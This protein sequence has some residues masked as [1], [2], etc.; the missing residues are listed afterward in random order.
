MAWTRRPDQ[1]VTRDRRGWP[2]GK[3]RR[4]SSRTAEHVLVLH[5]A[6]VRKPNAYFTGATAIEQAWRTTYPDAPSPSL[7]FIGRTLR[8]HGRTRPDYPKR[9]G[10]ARYLAYPAQTLAGLG[11]TTLEIDFIGRKYIDGHT[12]PLC[13]IAFSLRGPRILKY[14]KRIEAESAEQAIPACREFFRRFERP[15]VAKVDNGFGF[16]AS[17]RWA[18]TVGPMT[19]FLLQERVIPVFTAPRR[20]WNQASVEGA[21]SVFGRK[22]WRRFRFRT[23]TEVD[24][25]LVGFN[26]AYRAYTGYHAPPKR[27][28]RS[29]FTPIVYYIRKVQE[30]AGRRA[31]VV[32]LANSKVMLPRAYI[33]LFVLARWDLKRNRLAILHERGGQARIIHQQPFFLHESSRRRLSGFI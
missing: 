25:R 27:R 13:F 18:C 29:P 15:A 10:A 23:V 22:F 17:S 12:A 31:G 30:Q 21:N 24:R 16:A 33:N 8:A 5:D 20:P 1:E 7:R 4:Y 28:R 3:L 14:F 9:H 32:E 6:L 2:T 19:R 11:P 26:A